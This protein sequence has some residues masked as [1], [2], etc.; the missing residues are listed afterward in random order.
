MHIK[1]VYIINAAKKHSMADTAYG[2]A[3]EVHFN[4]S[5]LSDGKWK[6]LFC[7][8]WRKALIIKQLKRKIEVSGNDLKLTLYSE[9]NIQHYIDVVRRII[10]KIDKCNADSHA[11]ISRRYSVV[12]ETG[13]MSR[14]RSCKAAK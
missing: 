8:E 14:V 4:L 7:C 10:F 5:D 11:G 9:D 2:Q 6:K 1:H 3:Y 13:I 12:C